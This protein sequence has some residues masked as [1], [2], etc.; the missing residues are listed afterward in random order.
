MS[1]YLQKQDFKT[2]VF[3]KKKRTILFGA[4]RLV[5]FHCRACENSIELS[6]FSDGI[7]TENFP[8]F[9]PWKEREKGGVDVVVPRQLAH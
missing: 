7:L 2:T 4:F 1:P 6:T 8:H 3:E 5:D 9:S